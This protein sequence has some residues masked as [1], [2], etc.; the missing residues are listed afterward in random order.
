MD[1]STVTDLGHLKAMAYDRIVNKA[2][3]EQELNL[4]NQRIVQLEQAEKAESAKQ[5]DAPSEPR[6]AP[7]V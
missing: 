2:R 1:L 4:I 6:P 5:A 7:A 3:A